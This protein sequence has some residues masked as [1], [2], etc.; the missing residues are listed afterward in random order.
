LIRREGDNEKS[1]KIEE[2]PEQRRD[3]IRRL[4]TYSYTAEAGNLMI[5]CKVV[6]LL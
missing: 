2:R 3:R 4:T 5:S 1:K 6:G